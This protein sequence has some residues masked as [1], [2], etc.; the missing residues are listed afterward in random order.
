MSSR[1][2][3]LR[4]ALPVLELQPGELAVGK[5]LTM[6]LDR[7]LPSARTVASVSS[8][9]ITAAGR[10]AG[11]TAVTAGSAVTGSRSVQWSFSGGSVGERYKVEAVILDDEGQPWECEGWLDVIDV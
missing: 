10:I 1:T 8:L 2:Q 3:E 6:D 5:A 9:T 4:D 7:V 11:A